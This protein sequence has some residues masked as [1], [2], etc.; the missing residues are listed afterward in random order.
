MPPVVV[1]RHCNYPPPPLPWNDGTIASRRWCWSRIP[2]IY[3]TLRRHRPVVVTFYQRA[4][5]HPKKCYPTCFFLI[6]YQAFFRFL[7]FLGTFSRVI[8]CGTKRFSIGLV[9]V[10]WRFIETDLF[11]TIFVGFTSL[12]RG[13]TEFY[14]CIPN[15][16]GWRPSFYGAL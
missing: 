8:F 12:K 6:L 7:R 9:Y 11:L 4:H 3:R 2:S 10:F 5:G 14:M 16:N 15:W 1:I 13:C